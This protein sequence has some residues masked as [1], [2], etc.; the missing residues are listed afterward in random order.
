MN[1]F[2][3]LL[4]IKLR[5]MLDPVVAVQPPRRGGLKKDRKPFLALETPL[6][7]I[8]FG[9]V[10]AQAIPVVETPLVAVAPGS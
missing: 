10:V 5:Q 8:A 4:E 1:D 9:G 7:P 2:D 3:R 6:E